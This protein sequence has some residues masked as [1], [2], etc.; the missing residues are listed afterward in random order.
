MTLPFVL[1]VP[2]AGWRVPE[3][4]SSYSVLTE[5]EIEEDGDVGAR[6]I[7][8]LESELEQFLTTDVARAFVDLNRA[9][10]DRRADGVVKTHTCWNVPVYREPLPESV[11]RALLR[12]YYEPYHARLDALARSGVKLGIDGHTMAAEGPPVGPDAGKPRPRV[13]LSF[14]DG[15]VPSPWIDSLLGALREVFGPDVKANDP[16]QGGYIMRHHGRGLPFVQLELSRAAWTT[17]ERKRA[18]V[19]EALEALAGGVRF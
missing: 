4:V 3:E 5:S 16:F 1:S 19:L 15:S 11:V 2:H 17:N 14:V 13:C 6:D 7:Y 10:D 18:L 9:P 8:A 12:N